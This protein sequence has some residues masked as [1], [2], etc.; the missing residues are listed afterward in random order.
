MINAL[1]VAW[2]IDISREWAPKRPVTRKNNFIVGKSL[3]GIAAFER[4]DTVLS[5]DIDTYHNLHRQQVRP[6][7]AR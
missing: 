6:I 7:T 1:A 3:Y 2:D 5:Q 4:L